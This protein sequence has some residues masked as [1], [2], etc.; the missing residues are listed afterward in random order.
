MKKIKAVAIISA[1][2]VAVLIYNFLNTMSNPAL[3]EITKTGVITAS[4]DIPPNVIITEEMLL[5]S[6]IPNEATHPQAVKNLSDAIGKVSSS[7][8]IQGEQVLSSKLIVPGEGKAD[9]SLAYSIEPGMRAVTIA[10]DEVTGISNMIVP[11]NHV[12]IIG[13][14]KVKVEQSNGKEKEIDYTTMLLENVKVL[15]VDKYKTEQEKAG[16]ENSY[17]TITIQVTPLQAM[18][19]SMSEFT[20]QLRAVLRS[21]LDNNTTSLPALTIEKIIFKNK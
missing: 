13:Q 8:I 14:Y 12:D 7:Q 3:K 11:N 4:Q 2:I 15:A 9:G 1:V 18:E 19:T 5:V 16:A 10:V 17:V 6:Q 20:G 21:P